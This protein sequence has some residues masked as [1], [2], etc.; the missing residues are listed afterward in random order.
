M[1]IHQGLIL[2]LIGALSGLLGGILGIGG[3]VV[4]IPALVFFLGFSQQSAQ[5]TTLLMLSLP[6][7]ALAAF[8]YYR[9]GFVEVKSSLILAA[10]FFV[11]GFFGAKIAVQIP[12]EALK[13][14]FGVLLLV[15]AIKILFLDK[16]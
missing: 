1:A 16:K 11:G 7:G 13:K 3:A 2:A 5:G 15:L 8:Q 9:S 6:V 12:Q 14:A 4:I 10:F